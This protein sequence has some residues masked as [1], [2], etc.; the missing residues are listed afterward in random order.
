MNATAEMTDKELDALARDTL[1][2]MGET[3]AIPP[4]PPDTQE[5]AEDQFLTWLPRGNWIWQ[6][7]TPAELGSDAEGRILLT[8]SLATSR[9][10]TTGEL[11]GIASDSDNKAR[12][13]ALTRLQATPE[14]AS[15]LEAKA[16]HTD[17]KQRL[18]TLEKERR[19]LESEQTKLAARPK[20]Q[21]KRL[22][23]IQQR[24]SE[25]S[26]EKEA[27][28]L[29]LQALTPIL[30]DARRKAEELARQ[31]A[32]DAVSAIREEQ[33]EALEAALADFYRRHS[34]ELTDLAARLSARSRHRHDTWVGSIKTF[35]LSRLEG[36]QPALEP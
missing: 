21:G 10:P 7:R 25:I 28:G 15:F 29:E 3:P 23:E 35:I 8:L 13:D 9:Q 34:N 27:A 12:A 26:K 22:V 5:A 20:G 14:W 24:Q 32:L 4:E 17:V 11:N 31:I 6:G 30:S 2:E 16:E 33:M 18:D 1:A 36:A 19:E